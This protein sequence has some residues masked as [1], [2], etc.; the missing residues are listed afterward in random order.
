MEHRTRFTTRVHE[1]K[2]DLARICRARP[3]W[4][5]RHSVP[6]VFARYARCV[7]HRDRKAIAK[8]A[9]AGQGAEVVIERAIFLH[10]DHDVFDIA[11]RAVRTIGGDRER[12]L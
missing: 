6:D 3:S 7:F 9:H 12:L 10:Q 2:R 11:D 8:A 4:V 5:H 1:T